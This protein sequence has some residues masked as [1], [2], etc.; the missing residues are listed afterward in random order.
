MP[1]F[2][3]IA[4]KLQKKAGERILYYVDWTNTLR[5]YSDPLCFSEE[6][7]EDLHRVFNGKNVVL[8]HAKRKVLPL[9]QRVL[10]LSTYQTRRCYNVNGRN[11]VQQ[12]LNEYLEAHHKKKS[13]YNYRRDHWLTILSLINIR[14]ME[15]QSLTYNG[16]LL[17]IQE[18]FAL[19]KRRGVSETHILNHFIEY[20]MLL[21]DGEHVYLP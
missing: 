9:L 10:A 20:G 7:K 6:E 12:M 17:L 4:L 8:L 14:L 15:K 1:Y 13:F 19:C 18:G 21:A 5:R 16:V 11:T 2:G 3:Y